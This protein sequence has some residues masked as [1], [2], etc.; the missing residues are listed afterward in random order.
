MGAIVPGL[1]LV[2]CYA[3]YVVARAYI[4]PEMAPAQEVKVAKNRWKILATTLLPPFVL[5][6][7]VLGSILL[8]IATPT[9]AAGVGAFGGL[10][11]A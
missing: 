8:G 4:S 10:L 9:E 2:F 6:T 5:I 3:A 1:I 7:S 11:L